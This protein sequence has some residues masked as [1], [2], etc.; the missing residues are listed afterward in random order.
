MAK[1]MPEMEEYQYGF[2]DEHKAVFQSGKGLTQEIVRTISQMK[3]EP[4]WMLEFRLK[5]LAQFE[6]MAM[7]RWGGNMDELDFNEIQYYVKPSE[8]QGKTWEEVPT[9]IKETFDKLGIPEAEQKFLAGVSAQYESE[10]VYHSMQ[11]DLEKQGVIFTDTD[12]ALREHPEIFKEYF[13]TIVR[14]RTTSSRRSTAPYG[15]GAAS[16]TCRR[17]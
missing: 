12:T 5:S 6:K 1:K 16:F 9:E 8:K 3:S 10:V 2:R 15:P 17:V 14:R 11:E 7:P 4:E 13:G